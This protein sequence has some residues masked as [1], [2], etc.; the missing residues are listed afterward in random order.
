MLVAMGE[1]DP[2]TVRLVDLARKVDSGSHVPMA[3]LH[4]RGLV[5]RERVPR[6]EPLTPEERANGKQLRIGKRPFLYTLTDK[7]KTAAHHAQA[8][9]KLMED[10]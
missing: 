2:A 7:G 3:R 9:A 10:V 6:C 8:L 4:R 5:T 1:N